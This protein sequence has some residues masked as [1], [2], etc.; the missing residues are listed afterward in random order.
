MSSG[1]KLLKYFAITFCGVV[2]LISVFVAY[3]LFAPVFSHDEQPP[4]SQIN[5]VNDVS[6][7]NPI[8]VNRAVS[9]RT[10]QEIQTAIKTSQGKISIG[11]GRFSQGGQIAIKDSLHLDMRQ[12]NQVVA[13][14]PSQREI[15]VQSGMTWRDIQEVIDPYD[16]SIKIMQSYSNFTVGGSLS[17]NVHGRYM[18]EGPIIRSVKSV[19]VVLAD[20][21]IVEA[22]PSSNAELFYGVMG[23]YGGLGVIVEATL[24]LVPNVKVARQ[25]SYMH[26]DKYASFF[27]KHIKNDPNVVFHNAGLYPPEY[28]HVNS[29]SWVKTNKPVT[30]KARLIPRDKNYWWQ[31]QVADFVADS[32]LGKW[33]RQHVFDPMHNGVDAVHW[34]NYE[35]SYDV[36]ELEPQSRQSNTYVLREY[37]VPVNRFDQ[38]AAK[39]ATIFK[40]YDVNVLN[41]SV[42]HAQPDTGSLLAWAREETFAFV[43]YYRQGTTSQDKQKVSLWSRAMID[44]VTAEG[45]TYYLP[46]Q[47][48]ATDTQFHAAYPRA[49]E[50]F[51]LKQKLDPHNRFSNQLWDKY[52]GNHIKPSHLQ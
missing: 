29:V 31:P 3:V 25:T 52:Y 28:T 14:T 10:I 41:V 16:L 11:G 17:V 20:G 50:F 21:D 23:G 36:R 37:F 8:V 9:P 27:K 45:G 49:N 30:V 24:E 34:R 35:A 47:L 44:A 38:F 6:Q 40:M 43:V 2:L 22:S 32:Q 18:G 13:F 4:S 46:Y 42:R 39:M 15:T 7:L 12:F 5:I 1:K 26:V 51:T 19:K 48:H 33:M